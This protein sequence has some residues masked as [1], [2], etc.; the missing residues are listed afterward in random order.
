M[1]NDDVTEEEL[2]RVASERLAVGLDEKRS[3]W[4]K[5]IEEWEVKGKTDE[6]RRFWCLT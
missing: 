5:L 2:M 4:R 3:G 1:L 6:G